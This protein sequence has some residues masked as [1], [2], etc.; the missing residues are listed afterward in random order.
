MRLLVKVLTVYSSDSLSLPVFVH[1]YGLR[2]EDS[3]EVFLAIQIDG[4]TR[5]RTALLPL[6]GPTLPLNHTFNL[7]LEGARQLRVVVLTAGTR[8]ETWFTLG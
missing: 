7:E 4:V 5:A 6:R 1:V 2:S 8:T 3:K